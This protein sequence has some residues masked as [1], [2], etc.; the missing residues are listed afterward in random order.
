MSKAKSIQKLSSNSISS[1]PL[2]KKLHE[3]PRA[4]LVVDLLQRTVGELSESIPPILWIKSIKFALALDPCARYSSTICLILDAVCHYFPLKNNAGSL[5]EMR[6]KESIVRLFWKYLPLHLQ[7]LEQT[8]KDK[9]F[10]KKLVQIA[11]YSN[12]QEES[13]DI[14]LQNIRDSLFDPIDKQIIYGDVV[15][16]DDYRIFVSVVMSGLG[17]F[18][19]QY[20]AAGDEYLKLSQF[21]SHADGFVADSSYDPL[22]PANMAAVKRALDKLTAA[23][24][25]DT[26]L[27][28][29][30]ESLVD[31]IMAALSPPNRTQILSSL[32]HHLRT[33]QDALIVLSHLYLIKQIVQVSADG[34]NV[35]SLKSYYLRGLWQV[36]RQ[37][38]TDFTGLDQVSSMYHV[39]SIPKG[40][41]INADSLGKYN[42]WL[43]LVYDTV[44]K[45][46]N[47]MTLAMRSRVEDGGV[48]TS[49]S[50]LQDFIWKLPDDDASNMAILP[51]CLVRSLWED[52]FFL[53][54]QQN[55][56]C[57]LHFL[58][59]D[60]MN[61]YE[62]L[63]QRMDQ[64][65]KTVTR[66]YDS[67]DADNFNSSDPVSRKRNLDQ[68]PASDE[69]NAKRRKETIEEEKC[70][71]KPFSQHLN[72]LL[73]DPLWFANVH[74]VLFEMDSDS[75]EL[76]TNTES[77]F[78]TLTLDHILDMT[79]RLLTSRI[80]PIAN[81]EM[82]PTETAFISYLIT[83]E[84]WHTLQAWFLV[85]YPPAPRHITHLASWTQHLLEQCLLPRL[86]ANAIANADN[87]F[88]ACTATQST[89]ELLLIM[90]I[91]Q[92]AQ[93]FFG[94]VLNVLKSSQHA[95]IKL[96]TQVQEECDSLRA[97]IW[98]ICYPH[99]VGAVEARSNVAEPNELL[100]VILGD[101]LLH[102]FSYESL[103]NLSQEL[104]IK[105]PL[106]ETRETQVETDH[107]ELEG[108]E[109]K[110]ESLQ[111]LAI[112][113]WLA[114]MKE[115]VIL[116]WIYGD[117][118]SFLL[119]H[120]Q[121]RF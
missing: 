61:S 95:C 16:Y 64:Q 2:P 32:Q 83:L 23:E 57:G 73:R 71:E 35:E 92:A 12:F 87:E 94:I 78:S 6:L 74:D 50:V 80:W 4:C 120:E 45:E 3:E 84:L 105:S 54:S 58:L 65:V 48:Q 90:A 49:L 69:P 116:P 103:S 100:A 60:V 98:K 56:S 86:Q 36:Q 75:I 63:S 38:I 72:S 20:P 70:E 110:K 9:Q 7:C 46:R 17:A 19:E 115:T 8:R 109:I 11:P 29:S 55:M 111:S 114:K 25:V 68:E 47:A 31:S 10:L 41:N 107:Q 88:P 106:N 118:Q 81:C 5:S 39:S 97:H 43:E 108:S 117:M 28:P 21:V 26:L 66:S 18:M 40:A 96:C 51:A 99:V 89:L 85:H 121:N 1:N 24:V 14:F 79:L 52:W 42:S 77:K 53:Q 59:C 33:A 15:K 34:E 93:R 27:Q 76:N 91:L 44:L 113:H 82:A 37:L 119:L 102:L 104:L 101:A 13:T 62:V 67:E 22:L 30:D 112:S